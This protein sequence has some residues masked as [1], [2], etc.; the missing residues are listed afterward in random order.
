MLAIDISIYIHSMC[1]EYIPLFRRLKT[2]EKS[3]PQLSSQTI[4]EKLNHLY[5]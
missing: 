2:F 3:Q 5:L 4:K 1:V